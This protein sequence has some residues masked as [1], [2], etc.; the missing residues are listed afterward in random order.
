M[1]NWTMQTQVRITVLLTGDIGSYA[2]SALAQAHI[3]IRE[4]KH[5]FPTSNVIKAL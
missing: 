5:L 2:T 1:P 4:G 3:K